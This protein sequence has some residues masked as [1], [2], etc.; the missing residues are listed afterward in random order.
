MLNGILSPERIDALV[1]AGII[2]VIKRC[3][4]DTCT[5]IAYE[6]GPRSAV[7]LL[8]TAAA[9]G[10]VG[11]VGILGMVGGAAY[12]PFNKVENRAELTAPIDQTEVEQQENPGYIASI[13]EAVNP[14]NWVKPS[15]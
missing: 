6:L 14:I 2:D 13:A 10:T 5:N 9:V 12:L 8:Y 7:G 1:K 11:I 15:N 3:S 4:M